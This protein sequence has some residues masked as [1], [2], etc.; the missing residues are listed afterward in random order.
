MPENPT[1]ILVQDDG[2]VRTITLNRPD[3]LNAFNEAMISELSKAVRDAEKDAAVRCVVITGA[4]RA[5]CSGQDLAEVAHRYKGDEPIELGDRLRNGYNPI[6]AKLRTME[7]PVI[8]S[9]NGVAAGAGAS[10]ALAGDL[11]IAAESASFVQAFIHVG[12][13]PDCGSTFFLPRLV[14][15]A[16]AAELTMTGRKLPAAEAFQMGLVNQVVPDA[17]LLTTTTALAK[18]LASLPPRGLALT[19]RALNA[20]WS[21]DLTTQ[22]DFEAMLQTTAGKTRDHR[23]GVTAFLEKRPP[24]FRGE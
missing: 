18:K 22:L 16:R 10:L 7:K 24:Q 12:L 14:G 11:R 2:G 17:Q 9:V 4:G 20:A 19:K 3:V 21:A 5:F 1:A 8:A 6:I 23:E 15:I 13:V